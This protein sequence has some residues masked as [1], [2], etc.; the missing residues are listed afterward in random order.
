MND[1]RLI[2]LDMDGTLLDADHATIP[3]RNKEALRK[4]HDA[5]VKI[6]IASG[7]SWTLVEEYAR[8]LGTVDFGITANGGY[9]L[10]SVTGQTL[11]KFPM[12]TRQCLAIIDV[13]RKWGLFYE[14]YV[15]GQNYM[16]ADEL[17]GAEQYSLSQEFLTMFRRQVQVVPDMKAFVETVQ[18]EKFDIFYVP[19]QH[20]EVVMAEIA[21]TGAVTFS[22]GM[23]TNLELT[24]AGVDKGRAL[25]EMAKK[26]GMTAENVM[27]CGDANNDLEM[28]AWAGW[29]FAMGNGTPEAKAAARFEAPPNYEAG[30]GQA[31]EQYVLAQAPEAGN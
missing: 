5:G 16:Q 17:N 12:D 10:D 15:D 19:P 9:C 25:A 8:E 24:A 23:D 6:A 26:L 13:L 29:S 11:V 20:K 18:P 22:G 14:L 4:A 27:A 28:L 3:P 30:V 2:A 31:V 1:I 7:R 21:A